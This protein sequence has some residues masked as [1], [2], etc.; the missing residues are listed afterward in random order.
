MTWIFDSTNHITAY[1]VPKKFSSDS[2]A[3][4]SELLENIEEILPCHLD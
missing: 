2:E 3:F 4:A 1:V